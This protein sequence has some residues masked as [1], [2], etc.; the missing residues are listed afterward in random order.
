VLGFVTGGLSALVSLLFLLMAVIG[1]QDD[2]VS[3]C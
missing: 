3:S 2:P 1:G